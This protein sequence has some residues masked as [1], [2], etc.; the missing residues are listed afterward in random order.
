MQFRNVIP[1]STSVS[2]QCSIVTQCSELLH[3][4]C[5]QHAG[6]PLT[7]SSF[8][9]ELHAYSAMPCYR[10]VLYLTYCVGSVSKSDNAPVFY[11]AKWIRVNGVLYK[12]PA[13]ILCGM[14]NNQPVFGN[15]IDLFVIGSNRLVACV[16]RYTTI[17]F[18]KHCHAYHIE[19][20]STTEIVSLASCPTTFHIR[21]LIDRLV[22]VPK[23]KLLVIV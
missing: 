21:T 1:S 12:K 19:R 3:Y 11:S 7:E 5:K 14:E 15:I 10:Y 9:S 20:T 8:P 4:T 17:S 2:T 6:T 22:I 18:M 23:F 16:R 13:A